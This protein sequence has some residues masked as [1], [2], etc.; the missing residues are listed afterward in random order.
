MTVQP[1]LIHILA[2]TDLFTD[3]KV[4]QIIKIGLAP[5]KCIPLGLETELASF[6][7]CIRDKDEMTLVLAQEAFGQLPSSVVALD[8]SPPYRLITFDIPLDWGVIGYLAALTSELADAGISIVALSAFSRDHIFV[9]EVDFDRAWD[10]L[11]TFIR[12]CREQTANLA[13]PREFV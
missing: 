5:G 7:A 10:V 12:A 11:T 6:W 9:A 2:Q 8:V 1:E 3:G 13:T 4:Y